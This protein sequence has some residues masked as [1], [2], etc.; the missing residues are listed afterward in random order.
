MK[1]IFGNALWHLIMQSDM[2]SWFVLLTLFAMSVICW[3][4]FLY[5]LAMNR[6]KQK[7][8]QELKHK[9]HNTHSVEELI[10]LQREYARTVPGYFLG[11]ILT[12]VKEQLEPNVIEQRAPTEQQFHAI[13]QHMYQVIDD[14]V[15]QEESSLSF[16]STSAA[17]APLLGLFGTVWGLIHAFIGISEKQAAD[18]AAVA[19]GIAQALTTTL[20]GL[21]VA[22]PAFVMFNYLSGQVRSFEQKLYA[23]NDKL[24]LLVQRIFFVR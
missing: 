20:A 4:L 19:P 2:V 16:L 9:L 3:T 18:I 11:S 15:H 17:I 1:F 13:Q 12:T 8:I 5:K 7:H 10:L 22:I 23:L 6:L 14:L 24:N 21:M